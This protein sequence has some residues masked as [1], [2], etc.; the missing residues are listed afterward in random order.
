MNKELV[1]IIQSV[2][3]NKELVITEETE[4]IDD[5]E[6]SSLE[7]FDLIT[8]VENHFN[9]KVSDRELQELET[10]GDIVRLL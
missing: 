3:G 1:D 8:R 6:L 5:L 2:V 4:I 9:I 7:F 10:V